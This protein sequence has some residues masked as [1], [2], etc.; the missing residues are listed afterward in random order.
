MRRGAALNM[1]QPL[2]FAWL[3][4]AMCSLSKQRFGVLN[5]ESFE[6]LLWKGVPSWS[7]RGQ[8]EDDTKREHGM[9]P[10]EKMCSAA[11]ALS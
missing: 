10:S 6:N 4:K 5:I 1:Q 8:G 9:T 3:G 11:R 2:L 7:L